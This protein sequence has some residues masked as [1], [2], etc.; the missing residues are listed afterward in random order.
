MTQQLKIA[1]YAVL[2]ALGIW[3]G[4]GFVKNLKAAGAAPAVAVEPTNEVSQTPPTN[5]IDATEAGVT[6]EATNVV[7]TTNLA[8]VPAKK[9]PAAS[10]GQSRGRNTSAVMSYGAGLFIVI[11]CLGLL[12][13]YDFS[14]F[15]A[16]RFERFI[17]DEDLEGAKDPEYEEAE[18]VWANGNHLEAIQ[19]MRDYLKDHPREQYVSIRIAEIYEQ[20]LGNYLAAALEYEEIIKKK[21]PDERWGWAAIHLANLYSG[22]LNKAPQAIEL[23]QR[24]ATEYGH[25]KA[26]K[27]ARERL[28]SQGIEIPEP[29]EE[30]AREPAAPAED[31]P[32]P[33][34]LPPGF[35]RKKN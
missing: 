27:K 20:D 30:E 7:A 13:A 34:N 17:F 26:A 14:K 5:G 9:K 8:I 18:K 10:A 31:A 25:T 21:L 29:L 28:A 1:A 24:I 23:L 11:I 6:N 33:T 4:Y 3:F 22:K 35:R 12:I 2:L 32:P 15:A 19:L 16:H